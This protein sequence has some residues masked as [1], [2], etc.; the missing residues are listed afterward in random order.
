MVMPDGRTRAAGRR[1]TCGPPSTRSATTAP[2]RCPASCPPTSGYTYAVE[3]SV[4]E[5]VDAGATE[6]RFNQPVVNYVE[7]FLGFPVGARRAGGLLR[8][9]D[10]HAGSPLRTAGS[11]RSS[12]RPPEPRRSTPTA[13]ATPTAAPSSRRSGS[14][15]A[16]LEQLAGLYDP[17]KS[18][19]R[20]AIRHFT[21]WDSNW[22][23]GPPPDAIPPP[24]P[25]PPPDGRAPRPKKECYGDGSIIGCQSQRLG[26]AVPVAGTPF[27][28]RL[29]ERP[30][31]PGGSPTARSRSRSP[32]ASVPASL[33]RRPARDPRRRQEVPAPVRP[34]ART[35][36][37]R[38]SGTASTPTAAPRP[39]PSP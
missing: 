30:A 5:A 32:P 25:P 27:A 8:P 35:S 4:D 20:V 23:Y 19:W 18:L 39:A 22:P 16:E 28:L 29:L 7:N 2:R 34:G 17:G 3:L 11:S 1:S 33:A 26:Q 10:R 37:T 36:A 13:T 14:P 38:S 24:I 9:R 15:T 12:A 31:S 6:V 21:P